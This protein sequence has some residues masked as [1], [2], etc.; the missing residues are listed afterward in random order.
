M[1]LLVLILDFC[2]EKINLCLQLGSRG[3]SD[4]LHKS[5]SSTPD[6][7]HVSPTHVG[8][9]TWSS[10]GA[11]SQ[12]NISW[13]VQPTHTSGKCRLRHPRQTNNGSHT[14]HNFSCQPFAAK[15]RRIKVPKKGLNLIIQNFVH[16]I[17]F[18]GNRTRQLHCRLYYFY[19]DS[20]YNSFV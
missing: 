8:A 19:F 2:W 17:F 13:W 15:H 12:E 9:R 5:F 7:A 11:R 14:T 18:I 20:P 1:W 16:I 4:T 6:L 3:A 10:R